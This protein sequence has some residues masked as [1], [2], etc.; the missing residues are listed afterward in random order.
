MKILVEEEYGW[1]YWL[2]SSDLSLEETKDHFWKVIK[3]KEKFFCSGVPEK[4]FGGIWDELTYEQYTEIREGG[5]DTHN[6]WAHLHE[7]DDSSF[8]V[9]KNTC[10]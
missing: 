10:T 1:K 9:E 5:G 4:H 8:H 6:G 2:W 3:K 7:R